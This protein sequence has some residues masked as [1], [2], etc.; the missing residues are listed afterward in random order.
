MKQQRLLIQLVLCTYRPSLDNLS[1]PLHFLT[2]VPSVGRDVIW[3]RAMDSIY[4]NK[5]AQEQ[6]NSVKTQDE[7]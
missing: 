1:T 2:H 5:R 7:W 6:R 4:Y 3:N